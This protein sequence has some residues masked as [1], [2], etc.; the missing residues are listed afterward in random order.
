MDHYC[1]Y[2]GAQITGEA[3]FC[4]ECG[5]PT[6]ACQPHEFDYHYEISAAR[7]R[8]RET[9]KN[10]S[11]PF[12]CSLAYLP[13]FF[14][15]PLAFDGDSERSRTCA[16]QGAW[17]TLLSMLMF[18]VQV[19]FG[20]AMFFSAGFD[21]DFIENT[22]DSIFRQPMQNFWLSI[23]AAVVFPLLAAIIL[24]LPVNCTLGFLRGLC[25]PKPYI[26]PFVG[27]IRLVRPIT[28]SV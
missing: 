25:S 26:L 9:P 7:S 28:K 18:I 11:L 17:I 23:P 27:R 13:T 12:Y 24:Y 15:L 2:C 16:N 1:A 14:W 8:K 19:V 20:G 21:W 3:A 5:K 10:R 22:V 4:P 6:A